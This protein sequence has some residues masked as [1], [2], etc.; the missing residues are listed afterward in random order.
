MDTM[1]NVLTHHQPKKTQTT[2]SPYS[3][4]TGILCLKGYVVKL[5]NLNKYFNTKP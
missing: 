4:K 3:K 1:L 5:L 2:G